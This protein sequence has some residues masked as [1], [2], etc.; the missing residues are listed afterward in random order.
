ML[1]INVVKKDGRSEKFD[2]KK[3]KTAIAFA[4]DGLDVSPIVLESKFDQFIFDSVSTS[5]IQENLIEH[6]KNL[7]SPLKP[8]WTLVAGRLAT[9]SMWS[10]RGSYDISFVQFVKN[11]QLKGL[12][13]HPALNV[14]TDEELMKAGEWIKKEYDLAH[15]IASVVTFKQKYLLAGECIQQATLVDCLIYASVEATSTDRMRYAKKWY[16]RCAKRQISKATPHWLGLRTFGNTASCFILD[17]EDT[18]ESI[19]QTAFDVAMISS[20]GGGAGLFAGHLRA[21]GDSLMGEADTAS[22]VVPFI[23]IFNDVIL[24]FNQKGKRK[25]AITVALPIFHADIEDF[26]EINS[27]TGDLRSKS[28]DIQPQVNVPDL[29]MKMKE[30]DKNQLWYTFSPYEVESKLGIKLFD[31]FNEEF[32]VAYKE[33]VAAYKRGELSVVKTHVLNELWVTVLKKAVGHGTPYI[34]WIDAVNRLNPN[35]HAGNIY[36]F[37]LC[38]ESNSIFKAGQYAHTC[39][40]LSAVVGRIELDDLAD[41]ASDCTRMLANNL[42]LTTA[43]IGISQ[44][45]INDVRSIGIGIQGLID[46]IARENRHYGDYKFITE[47]AERIMFGAVRENIQL[48]KERGKYPLY[49]GSKWESGELFDNWI[50]D[51]VCPDLDWKELKR[52]G[53]IYGVH[54]SHLTSPAPNTST[55]IAMDAHAGV[56]PP[57]G[58]FFYEDNTNGNLPVS[59]MFLKENPLRYAK[60][61]GKFIPAELTKV[62]AALQ[63]FVDTGISAEYVLDMNTQNV[64]ATMVGD[65][66]D[67]SW[68]RGNKAVYYLRTILEGEELVKEDSGCSSCAG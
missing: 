19:M 2:C 5:E 65:L 24:A 63:L 26:L 33:C 58:A 62:V 8:D 41:V 7:A 61:I 20:E 54:L 68:K 23:K 56:M 45:H 10:K 64:D 14:Y 32:E 57:Y 31:L 67:Q 21:K 4:C 30:E 52:L 43:P 11:M 40:L 1:D 22:G 37:N 53:A 49:E 12:Y 42:L 28:F 48:A 38:T 6:A 17:M 60:T 66:Y 55:S 47:V 39:S 18:R 25:G 34:T 36:C 46:I 29:F 27:E 16:Q 50:R 51:S 59:S 13:A 15:S 44:A 9:M 35:P 3:I